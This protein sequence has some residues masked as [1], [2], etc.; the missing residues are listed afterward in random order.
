MKPADNRF[1]L[2]EKLPFVLLAL[3]LLI[4]LSSWLSCFLSLVVFFSFCSFVFCLLVCAL[5][6]RFRLAVPGSLSQIWFVA[7][8][9]LLSLFSSLLFLSSSC[10]LSLLFGN[11]F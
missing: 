3:A 1:K 7:P 6:R 11:R 9:Y 4:A 8:R 5:A 10:N 2:P